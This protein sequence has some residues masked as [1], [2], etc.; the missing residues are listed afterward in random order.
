MWESASQGLARHKS[1]GSEESHCASRVLH[2]LLSS[3]SFSLPF[4][5]YQ[6]I[7]MAAHEFTFFLI[8]FPIPVQGKEGT[9]MWYLA[10]CWIKPQQ[11]NFNSQ[12]VL[13]VLGFLFVVVGVF[14]S[15]FFFRWTTL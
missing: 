4:L 14:C 7:F 1:A 5:F 11:K 2:V 9:A 15:F 3:L 8:F 6:S 12:W 10:V 13:L